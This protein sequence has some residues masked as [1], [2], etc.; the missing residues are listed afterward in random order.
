MACKQCGQEVSKADRFCGHCGASLHTSSLG[1]TTAW[2]RLLIPLLVVIVC[3]VLAILLQNLFVI[4]RLKKVE[5][6]N[7]TLL[8]AQQAQFLVFP[9]SQEAGIL[10]RALKTPCGKCD[11][12]LAE[13][14]CVHANGAQASKVLIN[15]MFREGKTK[16]EVFAFFIDR[17]GKEILTPEAQAIFQSQHPESV[18]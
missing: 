12:V 8:A 4:E 18:P 14:N 6:D 1:E 15:N 13:N 5:A 2:I 17:Y 7:Q 16:K 9:E 11:R 3:G 10:F